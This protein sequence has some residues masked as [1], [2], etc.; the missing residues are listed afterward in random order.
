M[1]IINKL[2]FKIFKKLEYLSYNHWDNKI[3][4]DLINEQMLIFIILQIQTFQEVV[5]GGPKYYL[6]SVLVDKYRHLNPNPTKVTTVTKVRL[7][8][9]QKI[10][11][12]R[13]LFSGKDVQCLY[14]SLLPLLTSHPFIGHTCTSTVT[15]HKQIRKLASTQ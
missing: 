13:W 9:H 3:Q 14:V 7:N 12:S 1:H 10:T 8:Q 6:D 2:K 15:M 11:L 4:Q 5:S